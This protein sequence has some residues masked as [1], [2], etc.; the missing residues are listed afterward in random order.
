MA[1]FGDDR[2]DVSW[3]E[4]RTGRRQYVTNA[5]A[6]SGNRNVIG[7]TA[8]YATDGRVGSA[9]YATG[10]STTAERTVARP[11]GDNWFGRGRRVVEQRPQP[12]VARDVVTSREVDRIVTECKDGECG[13]TDPLAPRQRF[14]KYHNQRTETIEV[15]VREEVIER[16]I[17]VPVPHP[18]P[19]AVEVPKPY[20][21]EK[22]VPV[23][24]VVETIK[25]VPVYVEKEVEV[26]VPYPVEK[27]IEVKVPQYIEKI[28]EV[29]VDRVIT[30]EVVKE[31]QVAYPEK[32]VIEKHHEVPLYKEVVKEV[33]Y[34]VVERQTETVRDPELL[35]LVER[36]QSEL[37]QAY[38][39]VDRLGS[40][41]GNYSREYQRDLSKGGA[42]SAR[43]G[44]VG[45]NPKAGADTR[46][47][48][49][50]QYD[51]ETGWHYLPAAAPRT[52]HAHHDAE[53]KAIRDA[54]AVYSS[55]APKEEVVE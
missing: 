2:S 50:G 41:D 12:S 27:V 37:Q 32:A 48:N 1:F 17:E 4:R 46:E 16:T 51:G 52:H 25:E 39:E 42:T 36:L 44:W 38:K 6:G 29:P 11:A 22:L 26:P 47:P 5:A 28:V 14:R 18:V 55:M 43:S 54:N 49:V 30:K 19:Y 45:Y 31:V 13:M 8:N 35:C 34:P 3:G 20:P 10:Y 23:P 53:Q 33:P 40:Y 24:K 7:L 9:P 15:P 21:V